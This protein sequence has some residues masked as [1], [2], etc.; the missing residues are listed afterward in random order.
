MYGGRR[1][2][3]RVLV[4]NP[5]GRMR[6]GKTRRRGED[7]IKMCLRN[8]GS[9]MEWIDLTQ[10]RDRWLSPLN[11]VIKLQVPLKSGYFVTS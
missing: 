2:S 5:E 6:S 9:R 4:G 3:C 7:N 11:V 10:N 8:V 1:G